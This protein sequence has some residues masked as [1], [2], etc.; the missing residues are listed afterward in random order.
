MMNQK[1]ELEWMEE[2]RKDPESFFLIEH[3]TEHLQYEV[4]KQKPEWI[5]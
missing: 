1:T 5:D 2:I 4:I 3:P